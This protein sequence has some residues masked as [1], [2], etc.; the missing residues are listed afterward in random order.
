MCSL[1]V[2]DGEGVQSKRVKEM[3][4]PERKGREEERLEK[5]QKGGGG[6]SCE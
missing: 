4:A 5:K 2:G 6:G 3:V 1:E